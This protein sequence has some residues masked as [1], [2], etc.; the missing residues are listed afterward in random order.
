MKK[1]YIILLITLILGFQHY[2][3]GQTISLVTI[4]P[5]SPT[6]SDS[7]SLIVETTFAHSAYTVISPVNADTANHSVTIQLFK[8]KSNNGAPAILTDTFQLGQLPGGNYTVNILLFVATQDVSGNCGG[9]SMVDS[10]NPTLYV[11][12]ATSV[13][14][15]SS[16]SALRLYPNPASDRLLIDLPEPAQISIYNISGQTIKQI[17]FNGTSE[18]IDI[19]DL[20]AGIYSCNATASSGRLFTSRIIITR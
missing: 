15:T 6:P 16:S 12:T 17:A 10:D 1:Y 5:A 13:P 7:V 9:F 20:P 19:S 3:R 8:C 14:V 18:T 2:G 4:T 11:G